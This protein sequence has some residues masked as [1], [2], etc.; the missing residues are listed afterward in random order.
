M[1]Y[2]YTAFHPYLKFHSQNSLIP[3]ELSRDQVFLPID[4][5]TDGAH[6][7]RAL[8]SDIKRRKAD[9]ISYTCIRGEKADLKLNLKLSEK[10]LLLHILAGI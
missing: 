2:L 3:F 9:L 1:H 7:Y 10:T 4:G 8:M 6:T 5:Q